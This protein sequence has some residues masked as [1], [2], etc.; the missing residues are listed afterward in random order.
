MSEGYSTIKE[1]YKILFNYLCNMLRS[2]PDFDRLKFIPHDANYGEQNFKAVYWFS[3]EEY[4]RPRMPEPVVKKS[5]KQPKISFEPEILEKFANVQTSSEKSKV[6][7]FNPVVDRI[8][9]HNILECINK[10]FKIEDPDKEVFKTELEEKMNLINKE[11]HKKTAAT[12][13]K[14]L[15]EFKVDFA[16]VAAEGEMQDENMNQGEMEN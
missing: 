10:Q 4:L 9:R 11:I 16:S 15:F 1:N 3:H 14:D 7:G 8:I 12:I 13:G 5:K 2:T 6:I